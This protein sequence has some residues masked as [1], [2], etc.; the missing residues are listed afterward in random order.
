MKQSF[1]AWLSVYDNSTA[2][3]I[4][5]IGLKNGKKK[6]I[7]LGDLCV[8]VPKKFKKSKEIIKKKKMLWFSNWLG[9]CSKAQKRTRVFEY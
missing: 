1:E 2:K 8:V 7:S 6:K 5:V 3:K 9:V 4:K